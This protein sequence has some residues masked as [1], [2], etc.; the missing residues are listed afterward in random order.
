MKM[1]LPMRLAR[2]FLHLESSPSN[3]SSGAKLEWAAVGSGKDELLPKLQEIYWARV[4]REL[5]HII[6][7]VK[8]WDSDGFQDVELEDEKDDHIYGYDTFIDQINESS[9]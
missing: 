5:I 1:P 7:T 6:L 4:R 3:I 2:K 8:E 9:R